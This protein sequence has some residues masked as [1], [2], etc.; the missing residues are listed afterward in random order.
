MTTEQNAF[1]KP[2][3]TPEQAQSPTSAFTDQLGM[4]K[5]ETG[6]QK[7]DSVQKALDALAHSQTYIPQLKSDLTNKEAEIE[8]LKEELAK[9]SSV[10]EVVSKLTA[11]QGQPEATPQVSGLSE[12]EVLNLV[13][14]YSEQ[15]SAQSQALNNEKSVSDALF[16]KY[17]EK[18]NQVVQSKAAELGMSVEALKE[19]SQKTP[20]AALQLFQV[21]AGSAPKMSAGSYSIAPNTPQ[22]EALQKPDKSLLLGASSKEQVDYLAK[23]RE[24]VYKRF[25]VEN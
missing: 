17:G 9:R 4:I 21:S 19:L 18:T 8:K 1:D 5:N 10:E 3:E 23:V 13:Q 16:S 24:D 15:Q 11:P 22:A 14:N 20:Q 6:E 2:Q 25:N 7:Y 12:Q